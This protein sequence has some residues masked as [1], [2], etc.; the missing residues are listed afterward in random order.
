MSQGNIVGE[1]RATYPFRGIA[2]VRQ[3]GRASWPGRQSSG[4]PRRRRSVEA[5][6]SGRA[7]EAGLPAAQLCRAHNPAVRDDSVLVVAEGLATR[8]LR[9]SRRRGQDACRGS[10]AGRSRLMACV[11]AELRDAVASRP[12]PV[13]ARAYRAILGHLS[14][15]GS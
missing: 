13:T 1:S 8:A 6:V 12:S 11:P 15:N 9:G 10:R 2:L 3:H 5:I 14:P 7:P 4:R